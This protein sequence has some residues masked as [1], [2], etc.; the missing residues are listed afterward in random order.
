MQ[1]KALARRETTSLR[2]KTSEAPVHREGGRGEREGGEGEGGEGEGGGGRGR[3][4]RKRGRMKVD[5]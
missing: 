4:G 2:P 5:Q 3:E 1:R